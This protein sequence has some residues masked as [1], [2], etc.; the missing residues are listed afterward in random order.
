MT[1]KQP[2]ITLPPRWFAPGNSVPS[3]SFS[4]WPVTAPH[5]CHLAP[6]RTSLACRASLPLGFWGSSTSGIFSSLSKGPL[7]GHFC[8][9]CGTH[10]AAPLSFRSGAEH[11]HLICGEEVRGGSGVLGTIGLGMVG[12]EG[13]NRCAF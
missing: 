12:P 10:T 7:P 11:C 6:T 1:S 13:G 2:P 8:P 3:S 5:P 4:L 9:G